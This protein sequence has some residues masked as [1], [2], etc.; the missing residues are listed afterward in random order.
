MAS[1]QRWQDLGPAAREVI[2]IGGIVQL[3]LL[4]AAQRDIGRRRPDQL[5]GPRG[6]W[7]AVSFINFFG[8]IAY[9]VVGRRKSAEDPVGP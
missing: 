2:V 3:G 8:P 4:A 9:F 6:L 7:R 1:H 5:N